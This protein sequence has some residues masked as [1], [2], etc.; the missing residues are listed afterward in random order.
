MTSDPGT[1]A[2]SRT[3]PQAP[4]G[5]QTGDGA[6]RHPLLGV[7]DGRRRLAA[8]AARRQAAVLRT[9][10]LL[11]VVAALGITAAAHTLVASDQQR[12]DGLQAQLSGTLA[13]QQ[14]LRL[15]RAGLE[16]PA[17]VLSIARRS[18]GMV[19]PGSVEYL[20]PVDPGPSVA[21]AEAAA[22]GVG[23]NAPPAYRH[24]PHAGHAHEQGPGSDH[25]PTG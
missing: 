3:D 24:S 10:S 21:Q 9:L 17:R 6:A 4:Y 2:S 16:S 18:L 8:R 23:R 25:S 11:V 19:T 13:T 20:A 14:Q 1:L 7:V 22:A 5:A 15:T 12:I